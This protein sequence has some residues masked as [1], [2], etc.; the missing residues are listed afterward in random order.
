LVLGIFLVAGC[1][2]AAVL[3]AAAGRERT[4]ALAL[5][6]G[7]ERGHVMTEDDLQ[8]IYIGS[9]SDIAYVSPDDQATIVG[10]TALADLP[11]GAVI[12]E[13]QFADPAAVLNAGD[14]KI[15][16]SM[17]AGQL[18]SLQLAPGDRV[19]VVANDAGPGGGA[20]EEPDVV[21]ENVTIESVRQIRDATG[22]Q[23]RWWVSL[24]M[25]EDDATKVAMAKASNAGIQLVM[26]GG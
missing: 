26:V 17:E 22:Q 25:S 2:L 18:P 5:T 9:D 4:A 8:T 7:V 3:L 13:G 15:G 10:R 11:D 14:A 21:A 24:R 20:G 19:L 16:L 6:G 12:T 1:A 23:E